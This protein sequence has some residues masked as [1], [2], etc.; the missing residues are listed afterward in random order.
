[1]LEDAAYDVVMI[2]AGVSKDDEHFLVVEQLVNT[3]HEHAP[4]ARIAFNT[5]P[6]DSAAAIQRCARFMSHPA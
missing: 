4:G 3:V 2:G 5:G 1:M 6:T